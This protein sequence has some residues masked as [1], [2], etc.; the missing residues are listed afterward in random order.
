MI[1]EINGVTF[2]WNEKTN[3]NGK[4]DIGVIAQE[5][6]SIIPEAVEKNSKGELTVAYHKIIPLLIECIKDQEERINK[7]ESKLC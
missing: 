1:G 4:E 7:L 6:E 2:T 3:K 5:I